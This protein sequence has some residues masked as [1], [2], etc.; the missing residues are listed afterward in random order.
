MLVL[1]ALTATS[2]A[3]S[4][5]A[6]TDELQDLRVARANDIAEIRALKERAQATRQDRG[7][8]QAGAETPANPG[9]TW[10]TDALVYGG[11]GVWQ[12]EKR[13]I[14]NIL[15][16][17]GATWKEVSSA[18]LEA[19]S[20]DEIASF[21]LLIFPGGSGGTQT[22]SLSV[23]THVKLRQAIQ[24]RG[25]SYIG[26]CAGEW[27]AVAPNTPPGEKAEY[28]FGLYD[29][30]V[31]DFYRLTNEGVE[32]SIL[33]LSFAD[34][35]K[36]EVFWYGG[37]VTPDVPGGVVARHPDGTPAITQVW[38]GKGFM[39][40]VGPHPGASQAARESFGLQDPDGVDFDLEWTLFEAALHQKP[41]QAF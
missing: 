37:P 4:A 7:A 35:T 10:Q 3:P 33:P 39:I 29:G 14:E 30:K 1:S 40:L 18:E 27:I 6:Q 38:S 17:R 23:E 9:R 11:D 34:G 28:G 21:G 2:L 15:T 22:R 25:V 26:F 5:G 12:D 41:L 20:V 8:T 16:E 13:S 24:E 36:R 19:M 31:L 32:T